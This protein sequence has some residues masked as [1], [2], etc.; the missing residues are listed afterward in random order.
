LFTFL[1]PMLCAVE[2]RQIHIRRRKRGIDPQRCSVG[3]LSFQGLAE[4]R[5]QDT[6]VEVRFWPIG[7]QLLGPTILCQRQIEC[8]TLLGAEAGSVKRRQDARRL[9]PHGPDGV[10]QEGCSQAQPGVGFDAFEYRD[11]RHTDKRIAICEG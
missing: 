11:S 5:L 4:L 2:I 8:R 7:I 6:Q 9:D 1:V 3:S 10:P